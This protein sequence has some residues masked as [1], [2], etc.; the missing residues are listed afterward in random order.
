MARRQ[1]VI[2]Q[3]ISLFLVRHSVVREAAAC[4]HDDKLERVIMLKTRSHFYNISIRRRPVTRER[5]SKSTQ[6]V[7]SL[8]TEA[9][10]K[11]ENR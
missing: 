3:D 7:S 8:P 5:E 9:R 10:D 11:K 4:T 6:T 1:A 2:G